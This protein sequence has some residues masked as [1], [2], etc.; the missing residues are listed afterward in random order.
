MEPGDEVVAVNGRAVAGTRL[1]DLRERLRR[2]D[3]R[4][5]FRIKRGAE[6][7]DVELKTRRLV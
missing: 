2:P 4:F 5:T 1:A 6:T 3:Q 7:L